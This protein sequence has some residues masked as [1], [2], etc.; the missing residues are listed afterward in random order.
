VSIVPVSRVP[1]FEGK[2]NHVEG[3]IFNLEID[4]VT[5]KKEAKVDAMEEEDHSGAF[6]YMYIYQV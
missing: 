4:V 6:I 5:C 3:R 1:G 2:G